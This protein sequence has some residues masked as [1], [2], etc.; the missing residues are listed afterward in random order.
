MLGRTNQSLRGAL[1]ALLLSVPCA[2]VL[3]RGASAAASMSWLCAQSHHWG[4]TVASP[5]HQIVPQVSEDGGGRSYRFDLAGRGGL[6]S[7]DA[8]CGLGTYA[9]CAFTAVEQD[10]TTYR[11][12]EL[13]TFGLWDWQGRLYLLY[14][15]VSPKDE[16]AA[17]KRRVV[18][19][20]DPPVQVCN[21]IGDYSNLM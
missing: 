17:A 15:I 20:D 21:E 18:R 5:A 13:S 12:S 2:L 14:R 19:V 7:L 9:E 8:S 16:V 6:L 3:A 4:D 11:F 1:L 10:G